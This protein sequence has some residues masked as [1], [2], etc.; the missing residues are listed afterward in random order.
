MDISKDIKEIRM[1]MLL[2]QSDFAKEL[3][4][5]FSTV[6]RWENGKA[7]PNYIALKKIKEFC[8]ENNLKF[9]IEDQLVGEKHESN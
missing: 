9:S 7:I 5:S 8:K 2:S 6:N 3:G 4:V 1:K